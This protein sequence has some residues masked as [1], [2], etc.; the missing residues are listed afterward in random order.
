MA[1]ETPPQRCVENQF[2][3]Q[4]KLGSGGFATVW[5]ATD[6]NGG[7]DVAI[8]YAR[9][10]EDG[11]NN[12]EEVIDGFR[13]E[14][15][16]LSKFE[17]SVL[18]SSIIRFVGGD[19]ADIPYIIMEYVEGSVL[20]DV[21]ARSGLLPGVE[22][23]Q[24]YGFPV[25]KALEFLHEND[26]C[27]LDCKPENVMVR[28]SENKPVLIDYNT[29]KPTNDSE[30]LF[31]EDEYKA[32]EQ[33]P[34]CENYSYNPGPWSDV[35][36]AGKLLIYLLTGVKMTTSGTPIDGINIL[37]YDNAVS[38]DFCRVLRRATHSNPSQR[39]ENAG[40]LLQ[41]LYTAS[42]RQTASAQLIDTRSNLT[43]TVRP[44]D[45]IGRIN[46]QDKI[47]DLGIEDQKKFISPIHFQIKRND[48]LWFI[49]DRSLNGTYIQ[50]SDGW[51][52]LLCDEGHQQLQKTNPEQL[53]DGQIY[54]AGC[55][56]EPTYISPVDP[57][58]DITLRFCP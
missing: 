55:I 5:R 26:Y 21:L 30:T 38:D 31:Y 13:N 57:T 40:E 24:T 46:T 20:S 35:Y 14:Y 15:T 43:C 29:V 39:P 50:I 6:K 1:E 4:E 17:E 8:K 41:A 27:Y 44:G 25:L 54:G 19:C 9:T 45:S 53:P 48:E 3:L 42:G 12:I 18:P 58:Y 23:V 22:L 49:Y 56:K 10:E 34:N 32:P 52:L 47:P 7:P 28:E 11:S 51:Q 2:H 36:A 16:V 37:E 33:T